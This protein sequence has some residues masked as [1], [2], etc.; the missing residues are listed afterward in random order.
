MT[1]KNQ[2]GCIYIIKN[3]SND[4]AYVGKTTQ[5]IEDR[6]YQH[7]K[8]ALSSKD[9]NKFYNAIRKYGPDNFFIEIVQ[10][11]LDEDSLNI[12]EKEIIK[13][14]D[15][16]N[17]GYNST[18]GGDG[19]INIYSIEKCSIPVVCLNT[20]KKYKNAREVEQDIGI[21]YKAVSQVCR[22]EKRMYKGYVFDYDTMDHDYILDFQIKRSKLKKQNKNNRIINLETKKEYSNFLEASKNENVSDG[23]I[24]NHCF[25]LVKNPKYKFYNMKKVLYVGDYHC[26]IA[27]LKDCQKLMIFISEIIENND[28]DAVVFLGDQFHTH[29]VIRLEVQDFWY[30]SLKMLNI[31]CPTY[32]LIGNHD[33]KGDNESKASDINSMIAFNTSNI[34]LENINIIDKPTNIEGIGMLPYYKNHDDFLKAAEDLYNQGA[35]GLLIAHQTFTGAQYENGFFSEESIDPALIPQKQIV[36]GHIHK[37]QHVGKCFY[38]GT[39]KWD[40]MADVNQ[41]KGIWIFTHNESGEYIEKEFISTAEI[42]TPIVSYDIKEGDDLPK[43]NPSARN[44]IT[45]EGKTA[46]INKIKLKLKGCNIKIKPTDRAIIKNNNNLSINEYLETEF[47]P[48]AGID[49]MELKQFIINI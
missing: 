30:N 27:N 29:A 41:E 26:Q 24:R 14:L 13:N 40:T 37:S 10:Y 48:I 8:K 28:I 23:T 2:Y 15:S 43:I 38:P 31:L 16:F 33:M 19:G 9:N 7:I 18:E 35:T 4:K 3:K 32:L 5:K 36:S 46:W 39:P 34:L 49:R 17:N 6:F 1:N 11:C 21:P 44:Y 22:G 25:N 12:T 47:E 20:G 45:I 42:V